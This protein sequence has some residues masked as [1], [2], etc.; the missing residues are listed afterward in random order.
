[1]FLKDRLCVKL[2]VM[3]LGGYEF[4]IDMDQVFPILVMSALCMVPRKCAR[5][6]KIGFVWLS[7]LKKCWQWVKRWVWGLNLNNWEIDVP[8]TDTEKQKVYLDET[9]VKLC[10]AWAADIRVKAKLV[11]NLER[12]QSQRFGG[13]M[14]RKKQKI[15]GAS[16]H[17]WMKEE[18]VG[19]DRARRKA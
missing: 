7:K 4:L 3:D 16:R 13:Q 1:M 5:Y 19:T 6:C 10:T 18:E 11:L 8:L 12:D 17:N 2:R 15:K 9:G 14:E